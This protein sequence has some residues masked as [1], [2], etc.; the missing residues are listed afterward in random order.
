MALSVGSW[1][2]VPYQISVYLVTN[3]TDYYASQNTLQIVKSLK[4]KSHINSFRLVRGKSYIN[5]LRCFL[6]FL[7]L[8]FLET[9]RVASVLLNAMRDF[10]WAFYTAWDKMPKYVYIKSISWRYIYLSSF[11]DSVHQKHC[12]RKHPTFV[13]ALQTHGLLYMS[14]FTLPI[15]IPIHNLISICFRVPFLFCIYFNAIF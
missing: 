2:L 5:G 1:N 7:R 14:S 15:P 3:L 6:L 11:V 8:L 4:K 12:S 9:Y 10:L 13:R